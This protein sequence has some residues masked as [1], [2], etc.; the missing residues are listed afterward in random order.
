MDGYRVGLVAM[1]DVT[2]QMRMQ[3]IITGQLKEEKIL[4][5]NAD[6]ANKA[7][8]EFLSRMKLYFVTP[9][10]DK[11]IMDE[12]DTAMQKCAM[13]DP[14]FKDKLYEKY[15]S[16]SKLQ[17]PVFSKAEVKYIQSRDA[18]TVALVNNNM[19]F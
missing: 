3:N 8:S 12:L 11:V 15:L 6:A 16:A 2:D 5:R 1:N 17:K 9:E 13:S 4:R 18:V 7:K 10:N 14:T 19:T